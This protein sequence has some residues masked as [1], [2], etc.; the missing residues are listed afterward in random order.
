MVAV[1]GTFTLPRPGEAPKLADEQVPLV[2]A[3]SVHRRAGALGDLGGMRLRAGEAALRR[4]AEWCRLCAGR[5]A[6]GAHRG[7][8]YRWARWRKSFV[9]W[10]NREWRRAGVGYAPSAP[11]PVR[12]YA[13]LL[14]QC[15]R[16]HRRSDARSGTARHVS[17]QPG[18]TRLAQAHLSRAGGRHAGVRIPRRSA[19]RCAIPAGNI[20]RWHLVRSVAAGLC[21]SDMPAPT[22]RTGSTTCFR[23]CRRISIAR[24]FQCAPDDQ[25]IAA[26]ARR[27]TGTADQPDAGRAAGVRVAVGRNADRVLSP[28]G[29]S[30][31]RRRAHWTR[32]CSSL[33]PSGSAWSGAQVCDCSATYS[34]SRRCGWTDV[35]RLV[36]VDRDRQELPVDGHDRASKSGRADECLMPAQPFAVLGVGFISAVGSTAEASC[37][38]IPLRRQQLPGDPVHRRDGDWLVGSAV[39]LERRRGGASEPRWR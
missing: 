35:A 30:C 28:P 26:S 33:M 24:Y 27:G 19:I 31:G 5:P 8:A 17:A 38:A 12:A 29:R 7:R 39:G 22:T 4:A 3:D 15:V 21:A 16:R 14:R 23:S 32:C 34:S 1:K 37:A 6:S 2:D 13:D 18:R 9:V 20:G 36:A 11:E 10:G 25:Q